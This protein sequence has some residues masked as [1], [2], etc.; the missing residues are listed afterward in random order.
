MC[1]EHAQKLWLK[2]Q[3]LSTLG[4]TAHTPCADKQFTFY[5]SSLDPSVLFF[6][7][8]PTPPPNPAQLLRLWRTCSV[9][10]QRRN[11]NLKTYVHITCP[12]TVVGS[13]L[14]MELVTKAHQAISNSLWLLVRERNHMFTIRTPVD[15]A[16]H[17]HVGDSKR[18]CD[19]GIVPY[20]ASHVPLHPTMLKIT[21]SHNVVFTFRFQRQVH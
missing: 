12:T 11:L 8:I 19:E 10:P 20:F 1:I 17:L 14:T 7:S 18:S 15:G 9:Q 13:T 5:Y 3:W 16:H 6:F 21:R 2:L 4:F